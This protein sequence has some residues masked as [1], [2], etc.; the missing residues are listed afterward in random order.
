MTRET[1]E[2]WE[3]H[4][5]SNEPFPPWRLATWSE[6]GWLI[7]LNLISWGVLFPAM[8]VGLFMLLGMMLDTSAQRH[9]EHDRCMKHATNGYEIEQCR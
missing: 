1:R 8:L 5:F 3:A 9:E 7:L 2:E 6:R 4:R